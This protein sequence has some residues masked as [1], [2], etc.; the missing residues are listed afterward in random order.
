[1]PTNIHKIKHT[2]NKNIRTKHTKQTMVII[3]NSAQQIPN[4]TAKLITHAFTIE[5]CTKK[6]EKKGEE[7]GV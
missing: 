4:F 2:T 6:K 1:M 5:L 7:R 3:A